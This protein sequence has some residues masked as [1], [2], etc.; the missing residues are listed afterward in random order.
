MLRPTQIL[1]RTAVWRITHNPEKHYTAEQRDDRATDLKPEIKE[2]GDALTH[3]ASM[4]SAAMHLVLMPYNTAADGRKEPIPLK[5]SH[6]PKFAF[7]IGKSL[8]EIGD[9][10]TQ[11]GKTR[12]SGMAFC[13]DEEIGS[14]A[15]FFNG[16][17]PMLTVVEV[18]GVNEL[19]HQMPFNQRIPG[20][21]K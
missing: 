11:F 15:D 10:Q 7:E 1:K 13:P 18:L 16:M 9:I 12:F 6:A 4:T 21:E 8:F 19:P 14:L 20:H 17:S 2:G 5:N 3:P